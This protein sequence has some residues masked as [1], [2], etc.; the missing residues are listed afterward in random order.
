[1]LVQIDQATGQILRRI[2]GVGGARI[3]VA[4]DAIWVAEYA[5]NS[6]ARVDR[7]TGSIT[8]IPVSSRPTAIAVGE[9]FVWVTSQKPHNA[10]W[11][12]DPKTRETTA[13]IPVPATVRDVTTGAGAVW[14]TSGTY[15]NEAGVPPGPGR[16]TK[17]D[18]RSSGILK[19]IIV[20]HRPDGITLYNGLVWVAVAPRR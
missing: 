19:T 1:M 17:I 12:I 6:V 20:G 15:V 14:V 13:V 10:V 5:R 3:A 8:H 9:G 7:R 4:N 16:V 2:R 11:R 18:P